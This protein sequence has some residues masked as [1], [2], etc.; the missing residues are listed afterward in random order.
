MDGVR[1]RLRGDVENLLNVEIRLGCR[2]R[3]D[4]ISLIGFT[5]VQRGTIHVRVDGNRGNPHL[6]A[7]ANDAYGNLAAVRD[8]NLLEHPLEHLPKYERHSPQSLPARLG[9]NRIV[10]EVLDSRRVLPTRAAFA[11]ILVIRKLPDS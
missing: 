4:G 2:R 9:P 11:G 10:L 7:G 1:S 3:A 5:H 8:E 6:V